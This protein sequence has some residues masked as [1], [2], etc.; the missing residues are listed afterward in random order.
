MYAVAAASQREIVQLPV[1]GHPP[2]GPHEEPCGVRH[3]VATVFAVPASG[4]STAAAALCGAIITGWR[5][6][7]DVAFDPAQAAACQ[8]CAQLV[9]CLALQQQLGGLRRHRRPPHLDQTS[10]RE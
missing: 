9:S 8:R 10:A 6:F 5:I 1:P 2:A 3:A 7:P 4:C